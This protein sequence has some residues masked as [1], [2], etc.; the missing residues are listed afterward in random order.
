M[1]F[2]RLSSATYI[3]G[4]EA[5]RSSSCS[6]VRRIA[7][8]MRKRTSMPSI[9]NTSQTRNKVWLQKLNIVAGTVTTS[10]HSPP[11]V[12]SR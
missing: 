6:F 2:G 4:I 3:A 10:M 7:K 1:R 9:M 8:A 11:Q 5:Q 12:D